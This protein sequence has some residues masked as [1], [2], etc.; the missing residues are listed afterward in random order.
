VNLIAA[1]VLVDDSISVEADV[2][3]KRGQQT[4]VG[5]KVQ[6]QVALAYRC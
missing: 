4:D 2:V 3:A 1:E 6:H 5:D